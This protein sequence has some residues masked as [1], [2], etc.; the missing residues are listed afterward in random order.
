MATTYQIA[1][2]AAREPTSAAMFAVLMDGRALTAAALA[3]VAGITPRTASG[4]LARLTSARL[5]R[6]VTPGRHRCHRLATTEVAR[7]REQAWVRR[8]AGTRALQITPRGRTQPP[9]VLGARLME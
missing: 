4:H 8:F 6:V 1:E 2:I 9:A 7:M 3:E 5:L